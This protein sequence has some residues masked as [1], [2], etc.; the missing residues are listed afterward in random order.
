MADGTEK[1]RD[2]AREKT[3]GKYSNKSNKRV[4]GVI[5][6][7]RPVP[8]PARAPAPG[9]PKPPKPPSPKHPKEQHQKLSI[10]PSWLTST[11]HQTTEYT[12]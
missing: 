6:L 1:K 5:V 9:G 10:N 2:I 8:S 3:K 7:F 4:C 11:I 12:N